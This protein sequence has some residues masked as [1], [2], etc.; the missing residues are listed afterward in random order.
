MSGYYELRA[1]ANG[2]FLFNLKAGN[3][4]VVL[5]SQR[6]KSRQ[7]ALDGIASVRA[8]GVAGA[9]FVRKVAQDG[10]PYFVLMASNGQIIGRSE[11]YSSAAA[12]ESGIESVSR[13]AASTRVVET[14]G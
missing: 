13:N 12:M 5:S 9:H 6:Y 11:M 4:Q 14:T 7:S 8:H 1:L 2:E 3:H 10:S